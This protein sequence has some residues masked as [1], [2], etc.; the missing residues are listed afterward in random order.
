MKAYFI[1]SIFLSMFLSTACNDCIGTEPVQQTVDVD[2]DNKTT[3]LICN[4]DKDNVISDMLL[5]E[6]EPYGNNNLNEGKKPISLIMPKHIPI[7]DIPLKDTVPLSELKGL[8]YVLLVEEMS[9]PEGGSIYRA[10]ISNN[11]D[12]MEEAVKYYLSLARV[13]YQKTQGILSNISIDGK[14]FLF[15]S[16]TLD[17]LDGLHGNIIE[18]K[19]EIFEGRNLIADYRG[20]Y[21]KLLLSPDFSY[22]IFSE[23]I[24]NDYISA[25]YKIYDKEKIFASPNLDS[26]AIFSEDNHFFVSYV[27]KIAK[28]YSLVENKEVDDMFLVKIDTS[29]RQMRLDGELLYTSGLNTCLTTNNR[30]ESNVIGQYMFE[31]L[32]SPDGNYLAYTIYPPMFFS[33]Y[34][35]YEDDGNTVL[36]NTENLEIENRLKQ[37]AKGIYILELSTGKTAFLP[38]TLEKESEGFSI[39]CWAAKE[40]VDSLFSE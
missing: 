22:L 7:G 21:Y 13:F 28:I 23:L 36:V 16:V 30:T 24:D 14:R 17:N 8:N 6:S 39:I 18:M 1:I 32:L 26:G 29:I 9:G 40:Q 4:D 19:S 25:L 3:I 20:E 38:L 33:S 37:M 10:L 15:E 12:T 5:D 27:G 2:V 34:L 31:P 11:T 35:H